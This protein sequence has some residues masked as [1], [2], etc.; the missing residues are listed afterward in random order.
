MD[1]NYI[2]SND[3]YNSIIEYKS[4]QGLNGFLLISH[5]GTDPNRTDKFYNTLDD[6][7]VELKNR[8]YEFTDLESSLSLVKRY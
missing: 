7:I 4:V 3:I 2:G 1:S 6:L 8:G 5:L